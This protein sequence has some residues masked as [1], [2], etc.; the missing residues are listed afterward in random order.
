MR[1]GQIAVRYAKALFQS[2]KE[3]NALDGVRA[4]MELLLNAAEGIQ[5][6]RSLFE[7]PIID[8]GRKAAILT[9]IFRPQMS[10]LGLDFITMVA[11][12]KREE[13]LPAM[14]RHYISLYKEEK[15]IMVATVSSA[16]GL[17]PQGAEQ[18]REMIKAAFK[19]EIELEQEIKEELIGGF[20]LRVE[21]K[22]LD[23]SVRGKL[24]RIK[25]ELQK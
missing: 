24:A 15:G 12:N 22:M 5:D 14:A 1:V 17:D 19:S 10:R 23:A 8:S 7:S 4:D 11:G 16:A 3:Q 13:F 9:E 25:K 2:A 21:D 20:V 18:I 6:I